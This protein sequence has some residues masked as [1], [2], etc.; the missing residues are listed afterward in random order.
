[1]ETAG[2][3]EKR[4]AQKPLRWKFKAGDGHGTRSSPGARMKFEVLT[5]GLPNINSRDPL[6]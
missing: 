5:L 6:R 2:R 4:S 1:M 3:G